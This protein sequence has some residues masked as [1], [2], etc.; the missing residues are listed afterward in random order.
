MEQF[1]FK[2]GGINSSNLIDHNKGFVR[3]DKA[4]TFA[5]NKY[6]LYLENTPFFRISQ[7]CSSKLCY[8]YLD[9]EWEI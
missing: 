1:F 5:F 7:N 4:K 3:K 9:C 6:I 2:I 8:I